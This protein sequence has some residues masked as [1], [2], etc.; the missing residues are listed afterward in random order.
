LSNGFKYKAGSYKVYKNGEDR[1]SSVPEPEY[2]SP[3]VWNLADLGVLTPSDSVEL[4]YTADISTSQQAGKYADLAWSIA[5]YSYDSSKTVLA[6]A[7]SEGHVDTNFV[8]TQV[9]VGGNYQN[10]VSAEVK[11]E[12]HVTGQVLGAST[13]LPGTGAATIW[14]IISGL[15]GLIGFS[16]LKFNKKTMLTILLTLLSFGL[17]ISPVRAQTS[18]LSVRLEEPKTPS[19]IKEI[20]LKYVALDIQGRGVTTYCLKKGPTDSGFVQFSSETLS[21]ISGNASHCSLSLAI[22]DNGP[23]Q[24]QTKAVAGGEEALSNIVSLD[25]NTAG[26]GTPNDYRKDKINNCDY[27]IHF[28]TANDGDKTVKVEIYRSDIN[29]FIADNGS[30]IGDI[31]VG[32]NQERDFTN[33]VPDCSKNYNFVIRAFDSAGN[34][35]GVIGDKVYSTVTDGNTT[36]TSTTTNSGAIPVSGTIIPKEGDTDQENLNPSS[37]EENG[38]VLGTKTIDKNFFARHP[39]TTALIV[40][41]IL[42]IIIY[43]FKK[44]RKGKKIVKK[45]K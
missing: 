7:G 19:R 9:A 34:G 13:E 44:I 29:S 23:Y 42:G 43:A 6:L 8:G 14:M 16:L 3:G 17:I 45:T 36:V 12:N 40:I 31:S 15:L 10:S 21:G 32:S 38:Q 28:K 26:P 5:N 41:L 2:H 20:E 27:K 25:Y 11:Q 4:V 37:T 30:K 22:T 33:S 39:I 35:S 1:T 24:F 18:N